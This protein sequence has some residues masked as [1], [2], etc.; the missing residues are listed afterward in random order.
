MKGIILSGGLGT[1]LSPATSVISKQILPIY[2]KPLIYY[3]LST[4]ML[5]GIKDILIISTKRDIPMF[6]TLLGDGSNLGIK[7]SYKVQEKPNGLADAFILGEKF[8]GKDDVCLI[9]G[10]NIFYGDNMNTFLSESLILTKNSQN[11][12]IFASYVN[13]PKRYGV[14][15]FENDKIHSI[16]EKPKNPKS[17]YAV[18]GLY[19]Y[20]NSVIEI[21]KNVKPSDRGEIEITSVNN[22]YLQLSKLNLKIFKRGIVWLDTGTPNALNNA[23][24]L[25]RSI[26]ERQGLKIACIEEVAYQ[27]KYIKKESLINYLKNKPDS[28]YFNYLRKKI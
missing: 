13:D 17:N 9:L 5:S 2:D 6:R 27:M 26:E 25:I 7:L 23:S 20:P 24:N 14:V 8:I 10:D 18:T 22:S 3:P 4:L 16:E 1:R 19:F 21:A 12:T 28:D 15:H 11:A